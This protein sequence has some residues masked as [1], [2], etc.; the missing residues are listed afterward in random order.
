MKNTDR[1]F[2]LSNV[3]AVLV[4]S[5][6]NRRY[7]TG[8]ASTFGYLVLLK[9]NKNVFIT[10]PRY[11][12]MAQVLVQD[13]V[14]VLQIA[15][16]ASAFGIVNDVLSSHNVKTVGYEDTEL[17]VSQFAGIKDKLAS[18][19][20]VPVGHN[21]EIVRSIKTEEEISFIKKAQS[22]TDLAFS[23]VLEIIKPGMTE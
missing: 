6:K 1:L 23:K 5:D 18:Y 4:V 8:F 16:G 7:F 2:E 10:D 17:T 15:N 19:E 13:G 12:E 21:I 3:D 20:C 11:Y 22:I 14:E 9:G